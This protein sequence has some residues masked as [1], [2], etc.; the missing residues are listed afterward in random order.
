MNKIK[1]E[2]IERTAEKF[3]EL[4]ENEKNFIA[5]YVVGTQQRAQQEQRDQEQATA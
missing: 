1:E 4:P 3:I 5:G 2:I